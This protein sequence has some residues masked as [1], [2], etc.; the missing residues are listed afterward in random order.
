MQMY[1]KISY[2]TRGLQTKT[3]VTVYQCLYGCLAIDF[4]TNN[5]AIIYPKL[6]CVKYTY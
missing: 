5:S 4:N 3:L 6:W 1:K 2:L